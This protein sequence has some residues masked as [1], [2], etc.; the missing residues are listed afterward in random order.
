MLV[1]GLKDA[2]RP[3]YRWFKMMCHVEKYNIRKAKLLR[4]ITKKD[5]IRVVFF[6]INVGMWKCDELF[7]YLLNDSR[8]DPVVISFLLPMDSVEYMK[9][10][11]T[12]MREYFNKKNFPY[13]DSYNFETGEWLGLKDI[14]PDIIFYAQPYNNGF[15]Q[16]TLKSTSENCLFFYVPYCLEMEEIP[17]YHN[18]VLQNICLKIFAPTNYHKILGEKYAYNKGR[19]ISVTGYPMTDLLVTDSRTNWNGWKQKE[20]HIKR[21]IWAPHHSICEDSTLHTSNFLAVADLMIQM[22]KDYEGKVQFAFKPHPRLLTQLQNHT[23][24]GWERAQNYYKQW[25]ELPNT[26]FVDG[27][28]IDLFKSSD[29]LI[30]DCS[31]FMGEYLNTKKP[32]MFLVRYAPVDIMN[33]FGRACYEQHYTGDNMDDVYKFLDDV[34]LKGKDPMRHQRELFFE[35]VLKPPFGKT[36]AENMYNEIVESVVNRK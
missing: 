27:E 3:I 20:T 26:I 8:F 12:N 13:I 32:V 25:E 31:S 6:T 5:R 4:D 15:E 10:V 35:N 22:A 36:V 18:L 17:A 9:S 23:D 19:N 29:A 21:V 1:S 11:Q 14:S 33:D 34:V 24:W 28:Y 16:Y 7:K 30:H 2:I